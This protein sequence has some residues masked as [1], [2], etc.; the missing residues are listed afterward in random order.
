MRD[1][2]TTRVVDAIAHALPPG[3]YDDLVL[4]DLYNAAD[5]ALGVLNAARENVRQGARGPRAR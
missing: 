4:R 1:D 2:L 3:D 5:A